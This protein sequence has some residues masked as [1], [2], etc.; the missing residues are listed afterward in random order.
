MTKV[1][2]FLAASAL[3]ASCAP[4]QPPIQRITKPGATQAE[5]DADAMTCAYQAESA[6]ANSTVAG[7]SLT[8]AL[9][10]KHTQWLL[11]ASCMQARGY[12]VEWRPGCAPTG[13]YATLQDLGC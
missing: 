13:P 4:S 6:T 2:F 7:G 5:Y 10:L 8:Q 9:Q 1:L 11:L 3:L 12:T